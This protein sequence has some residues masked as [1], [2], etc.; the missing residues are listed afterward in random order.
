MKASDRSYAARVGGVHDKARGRVRWRREALVFVIVGAALY[1][2][3]SFGDRRVDPRV[4]GHE[5]YQQQPATPVSERREA[6]EPPTD[7]GTAG[8]PRATRRPTEPTASE[9]ARAGDAE[10]PQRSTTDST[11][12]RQTPASKQPRQR[13][14]PA[15]PAS[16]LPP[17]PTRDPFPKAPPA[18]T[19]Q[20]P[21]QLIVNYAQIEDVAQLPHTARD[22]CE[23]VLA[24]E[25]ESPAQWGPPAPLV[26]VSRIGTLVQTNFEF[27]PLPESRACRPVFVDVVVFAHDTD[28]KH[29]SSSR[30]VRVESL[31]GRVDVRLHQYATQPPFYARVRALAEDLRP[32]RETRIQ[33]P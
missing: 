23:E 27:A 16:T 9:A 30:R 6:A 13:P 26:R 18:E 28:D 10:K 3:A 20:T 4:R 25:R 11:P 19:D 32:S 5:D 15:T 21:E 7:A 14:V 8:G 31:R 29:W 2:T 33:L 24:A 22:G 1:A 17:D 12:K